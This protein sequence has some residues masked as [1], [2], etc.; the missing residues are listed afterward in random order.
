MGCCRPVVNP[1][2]LDHDDGM[3]AF[4]V[5]KSSVIRKRGVYVGGAP[6]YIMA[7]V[8]KDKDAFNIIVS[9]LQPCPANLHAALSPSHGVEHLVPYVIDRDSAANHC[10]CLHDVRVSSCHAFCGCSMLHLKASL[11]W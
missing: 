3:E 7:Q 8:H 10:W 1:N 9:H 6:A 5:E 4:T 2:G 11:T